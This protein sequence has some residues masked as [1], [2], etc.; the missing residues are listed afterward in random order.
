MHDSEHMAAKEGAASPRRFGCFHLVLVALIAVGATAAVGFFAFKAIL[1][2]KAFQPVQLSPQEAQVLQ[3][4]LDRIDFEVAPAAEATEA[5][6]AGNL[7]F[8]LANRTLDGL[9]RH[10][11]GTVQILAAMRAVEIDVCH[12]R[13]LAFVLSLY[14]NLFLTYHDRPGLG[15][16]GMA[17]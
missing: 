4:K 1:F 3:A 5:D 10:F 8:L 6:A 14:P 11:F 16:P 2:P 15:S 12:V 7:K 17:P 13:Y 9:A